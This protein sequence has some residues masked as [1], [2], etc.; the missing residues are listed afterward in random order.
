MAKLATLEDNIAA[1]ETMR[2]Q[3]EAD[4][5]KKWVVF[6][7]TELVGDYDDFQECAAETVRKYGRGPYLIRRVGAAPLR[8]PSSVL[9]R[10]AY[11]DN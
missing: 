11:A 1:Y 4:H 9:F 2:P 7:N 10:P 3:L 6:Y 5:W 8:L